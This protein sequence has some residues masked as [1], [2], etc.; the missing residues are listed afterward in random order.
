MI[1]ISFRVRKSEGPSWRIAGNFLEKNLPGGKYPK[2]SPG[3]L[4]CFDAPHKR[5]ELQDGQ[6]ALNPKVMMSYRY[7]EVPVL[8]ITLME[9]YTVAEG[10][11]MAEGTLHFSY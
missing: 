8:G 2:G 7:G 10:L 1:K 4:F 3:F 6:D 9:V 11:L 5:F